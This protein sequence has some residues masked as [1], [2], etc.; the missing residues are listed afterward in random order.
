MQSGKDLFYLGDVSQLG[1]RRFQLIQ[2][3]YDDLLVDKEFSLGD[4][5]KCECGAIF[6]YVSKENVKEIKNKTNWTCEYCEHVND[7]SSFSKDQIKSLYEPATSM[8]YNLE[9]A[10]SKKDKVV[11]KEEDEIVTKEKTPPIMVLFVIDISGSMCTFVAGRKM[12]LLET[13][14]NMTLKG[15]KY[16]NDNFPNNKLSL[17]TFNSSVTCYGD[18]SKNGKKTK[19]GDDK[20]EKNW[21]D[22]AAEFVE[23][24]PIKTSYHDMIQKVLSLSPDSS[25]ALG[26]ALYSAVRYASRVSGSRIVLLT[27]GHANEGFGR[28]AGSDFYRE[29]GN[30][31][32][33]C[34]VMIDLI[35]VKNCNCN[36]NDLGPVAIMTEG[37]IK[38]FNPKIDSDDFT[39]LL[40]IKQFAINVETKFII[41]K[42]FRVLQAT[43]EDE[44][45]KIV[46]QGN[47]IRNV[48]HSFEIELKDI[49]TKNIEKW[50]TK[51]IPYQAQVVYRK[52]D[53]T[54][55]IRIYTFE[56]EGKTD[57]N[58]T[59]SANRS[60][61]A[62][63]H[64][65]S[66]NRSNLIGGEIK[67]PARIAHFNDYRA[68][69]ELYKIH[70][71]RKKKRSDE[72]FVGAHNSNK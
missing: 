50:N 67:L 53:G 36:L 5:V 27:D 45:I 39:E 64:L 46:E 11:P 29:V 14:K 3:D 6:S 48:K 7:I 35:S 57:K 65:S 68:A 72:K 59:R 70:I 4:P 62:S 24:L 13:V 32:K 42:G 43:N 56:I 34:G 49:S 2:V 33:E 61:V 44:N 22:F 23:P 52:M 30:L 20:N 60:E 51:L 47:L 26:P 18:F 38:M 9:I 28:N 58:I 21:T 37:D 41:P 71:W 15:I 19:N 54:K 55:N 17:M 40:K 69:G 10:V 16:Q 25:T 63:Y 8:T 31:A 66:Y 1:G 12:S